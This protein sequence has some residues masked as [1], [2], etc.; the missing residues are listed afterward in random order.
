[1]ALLPD[2]QLGYLWSMP[3]SKEC[4][5]CGSGNTVKNGKSHYGKQNHKCKNCNRQFVDRTPKEEAKK[6][7]RMETLFRLL[8]ERLSLRAI[9][10]VLTGS[11]GRVCYHAS[12]IWK[13][14]PEHLPVSEGLLDGEISCLCLEGDELWSFVGAKDCPEWVWVAIERKT[15]L[16]VGFHIGARDSQGAKGLYLSIDKRLR[17]KSLIFTD[18][19]LAYGTAF[20]KGQLSQEGKGKTMAIERFNNTLRQRCS[21]LVRKSLS[22]S[23]SWANHYDS[24]RFVIAMYN[25]EILAK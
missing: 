23:K 4:P 12:R 8:G 2:S 16:I 3:N 18:G 9:G 19:L 11:L 13:S 20:E 5:H 6:S 15:K 17:G 25:N 7:F 14:L 22:L 10:W 21:R 24:I 1:M